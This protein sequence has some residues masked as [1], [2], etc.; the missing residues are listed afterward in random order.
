MGPAKALATPPPAPLITV[1]EFEIRKAAAPAPP[2]AISS[3]G[4]ADRITAI[5]PPDM[6]KLPNTIENS[7]TMPMIWNMDGPR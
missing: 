7:T 6:M 4:K 5:L 2:I 1:I 3:C